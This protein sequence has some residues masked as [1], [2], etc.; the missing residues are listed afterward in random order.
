VNGQV[1]LPGVVLIFVTAIAEV[2]R[3][4]LLI[5]MPAEK[6]EIHNSTIEHMKIDR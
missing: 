4:D 2:S 3:F 5:E 6:L 1:A